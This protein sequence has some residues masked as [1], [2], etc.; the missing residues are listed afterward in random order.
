MSVRQLSKRVPKEV[1]DAQSEQ[2]R[3]NRIYYWFDETDMRQGK[4]LIIGPP[5]T[6]YAHCP[7]L[8]SFLLPDDYPFNPPAVKIL[9]SD[10]RTRFHPNLYVEGKVCLSIL[11]TWSGPKWS[12]VMNISTVL[13]SIQS[14]LEANPITNEPGWEKYT[15]AHPNAKNYAD[16]VRARLVAHSIRD[17]LRWRS[18]KLPSAWAEFEEILA[19]KG[20][21]W[22][23]A[24][25]AIAQKEGAGGEVAY[26]SLPYGM[27]G[28]TEWATVLAQAKA[29][30]VV[31]A[32]AA[33][34]PAS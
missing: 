16:F 22:L 29:A 17:L 10:H 20:E 34:A 30:G 1:A 31:P 13:S 18:G 8:F 27:S 7:L 12:A 9:T 6:P 23:Q 21:E 24:L 25:L 15:L 2:M 11:G 26:G 19:E 4:A 14:L 5:E 3:A 28:R 32:A 33:A